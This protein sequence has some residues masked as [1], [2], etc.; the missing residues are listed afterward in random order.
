MP[1]HIQYDHFIEI[2]KPPSKDFINL[3]LKYGG[4]IKNSGS[5]RTNKKVEAPE[6]PIKSALP[7]TENP[8]TQS[9]HKNETEKNKKHKKREY[10][11]MGMRWLS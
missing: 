10:I 2:T 11:N 3:V 4:K 8:L 9:D 7:Q 1:A 5:E 6:K